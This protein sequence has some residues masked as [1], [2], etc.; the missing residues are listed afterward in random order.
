MKE[1]SK[2]VPRVY[3]PGTKVFING[4]IEGYITATSWRAIG[5]QYEILWWDDGK[6]TTY[7]FTDSEFRTTDDKV[8]FGYRHSS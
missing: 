5:I 4:D 6:P 7:W 1:K 8:S 2:A 3:P